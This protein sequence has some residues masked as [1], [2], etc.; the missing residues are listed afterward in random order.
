M[1]FH[2]HSPLKGE[3]LQFMGKVV[4]LSLCQT[5]TGIG[6]N[7]ISPIFMSPWA[8]PTSIGMKFEILH[9][10]GVGK[11][12]HH[13]AQ[14]LQVI[15]WLLAP[16]VPHDGCLLLACIFN[17][18]LSVQQLGYL[19]ELGDESVVIT[20]KPK[21]NSDLSD[22]GRGRPFLISS[23]LPSSVAIPWAETMCPRYVISHQNSSHLEGLSFSPACS[24]LWNKAS[25]LLR[26][27]V[28]SFKKI[29]ISSK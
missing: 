8:R 24:S 5:P 28:G 14:T 22:N 16:V 27:L 26:W 6:N 1:E 17:R 7:R 21:E 19:C 3:K 12:R 29:T 25:S 10:I 4:G 20:C 13:S 23:F 9:K 18:H 15:K 2:N 11:N